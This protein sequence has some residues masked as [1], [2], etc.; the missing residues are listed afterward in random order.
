ML[1]HFKNQIPFL[2]YQKIKG[3]H[4]FFVQKKNIEF[5]LTFL[6][7]NYRSQ[8]ALLTQISA[9]D[10]LGLKYRFCVAYELLSVAYSTRLRVKVAVDEITSVNSVC[11]I[12]V[13]ANWWEREIWDMFGIY[14]K[15]HPDLRR[16]LTDY[17]FDSYPLRKDFPL[18]GFVELRYDTFKKRI[19]TEPLELSQEFR[20]FTFE[21]QW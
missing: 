3:E 20:T 15:G 17:G 19:I 13:C 11:H 5:V 7:K 4:S 1:S 21:S 6:Q 9:V 16:I 14:F 10:F 18:S 12:F 2:H 8:M